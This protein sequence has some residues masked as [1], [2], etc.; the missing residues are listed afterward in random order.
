MPSP[1]KAAFPFPF[2]IQKL[3]YLRYLVAGQ[4]LAV[5]LINTELFRNLT[6]CLPAVAGQHDR[7]FHAAFFQCRD[8]FLCMRLDL[9]RNQDMSGIFAIH[10]HVNN[11]SDAVT[12]HT[13]HTELFHQLAVACSNSHAIHLCSHTVAADLFDIRYTARIQGLA[14]CLL[15]ALADRM[16]GMAFRQR[17][18]FNSFS[19]SM[20]E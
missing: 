9:I 19:V 11:G 4:K 3:F 8:G 18:V 17:C 14:V 20:E 15:K 16:G 10:R 12:F 5:Y 2:F 7:L 13:I 1:T 6:C